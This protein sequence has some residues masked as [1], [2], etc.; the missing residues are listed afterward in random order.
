MGF[1]KLIAS[2]VEEA[3]A[4]KENILRMAE[5]EAG[6]IL[7][8]ANREK[9]TYRQ[10]PLNEAGRRLSAEQS[11]KLHAARLE[12]AEKIRKA[13]IDLFD[14]VVKRVGEM[15]EEFSRKNGYSACLRGL[16]M[17]AAGSLDAGTIIVRPADAAVASKI[18]G[19]LKGT[20]EVATEKGMPP[21]V[22]VVSP[23]GLVE[24][25]NTFPVRLAR[26]MLHNEVEVMKQI[27]DGIGHA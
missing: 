17:E 12:A 14:A 18:A 10:G 2:L 9:D 1:E 5:E 13:K 19:G 6:R 15:T 22:R 24:I 7:D 3:K 4:E 26:Y 21:G 23:D 20:F 16:I 8:Q 27:F 11:K 25:D